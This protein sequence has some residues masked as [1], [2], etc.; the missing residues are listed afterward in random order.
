MSDNVTFVNYKESISIKVWRYLTLKGYVP[1]SSIRIKTNDP[2]YAKAFG[3]LYKN[4][5]AKKRNIFFG[6]IKREPRMGFLGV[7]SFDTVKCNLNTQIWDFEIYGT[8]CVAMAKALAKDI[9][10]EFNIKITIILVSEEPLEEIF[11]GE[12]EA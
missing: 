1:A 10:S 7:L 12:F 4:P 11:E 6:L 9:A 8:K 2:Q 3:I 5:E